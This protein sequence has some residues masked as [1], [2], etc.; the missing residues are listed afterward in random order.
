DIETERRREKRP[1]RIAAEVSGGI[2]LARPGGAF[3]LHG[4]ADRVEV[5][6]DETL[7]ILDYKTGRPP[8]QNEVD[9]GLAPQLLLE[10]AIAAEAGFPD[11]A[12]TAAQL[13]YWHLSGGIEPGKAYPLFRDATDSIPDAVAQ[14]KERLCALID[15]FD[16][17]ERAYLSRPHP[18][19]GTRFSDYEQLARVAEWS[20]AGGGHE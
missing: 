19:H 6:E 10:A 20:S 7:A 12:G 2:D 11:V 1:V 5:Y 14:A 9:A 17:P 18:D 13:V 4:R 8:G 3:R 15:E 16:R